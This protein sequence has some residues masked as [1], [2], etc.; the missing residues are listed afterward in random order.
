MVGVGVVKEVNGPWTFLALEEVGA[1][2]IRC[3]LGSTPAVFS[4]YTKH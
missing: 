4:L 1:S 2:P 3:W